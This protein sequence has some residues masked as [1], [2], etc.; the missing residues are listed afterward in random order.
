MLIDWFTVGAQVLNFVIL[1]WLM[2]RFLYKPILDAIDAREKRI[3][4]ELA[5]AAG[6][7]AEA[8][9]ERDTFQKKNDDFEQQRTTLLDSARA[10]AKAERQQLMDAA[11]QAADAL[12]AKRQAA[13]ASEAK[14]LVQALRE[15]AQTEVFAIAHKALAELADVSLEAR[16][17]T[18]FITRLQALQGQPRETLAAA[19]AGVKDDILIRSAFELPSAQRR[20]IHEALADSF[21][22]ERDLRF[23]T[24][25]ALVA[26]IE[27]VAQGQKFAWTLDEGLASLERDVTELLKAQAVAP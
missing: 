2:K 13:L 16:A 4:D 8:Q 9:H 14:A 22:V 18:L 12:S 11:R 15:R 23:E 17:C 7:K 21:D 27:L 19:L 26:G 20:A 5:A 1:V 10:D 3:A 25:P 24:A 6:K